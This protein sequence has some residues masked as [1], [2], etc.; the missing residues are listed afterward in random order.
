MKE[1]N[2]GY[3]YDPDL[4][5]ACRRKPV[6]EPGPK[7]C[8]NGH[9]YEGNR[10]QKRRGT[11]CILCDRIQDRERQAAKRRAQGAMTKEENI[12][13]TIAA[14]KERAEAARI[15]REEA[16]KDG[17][18][19]LY[20][21]VPPRVPNHEWYDEVI[22]VRA[23]NRQKTGRKPYRLEWAEIF[24]RESRWEGVTNETLAEATGMN[25]DTITR[26]RGEYV[27]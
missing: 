17:Y 4:C 5:K 10:R 18:E 26:F 14:N 19:D 24:R 2:H 21:P 23:L 12:A 1:C 20:G 7:V 3:P 8:K 22:V 16:A 27:G 15:R 13:R 25:Q 9:P 11:S 6:P